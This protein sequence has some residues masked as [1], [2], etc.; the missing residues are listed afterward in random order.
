MSQE[1]QKSVYDQ[2]Q[3]TIQLQEK[4]SLCERAIS[5][6]PILTKFSDQEER[7]LKAASVGE[8]SMNGEILTQTMHD[9]MSGVAGTQFQL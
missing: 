3:T 2:K 1:V 6:R 4:L 7:I 8:P 5:M 9:L